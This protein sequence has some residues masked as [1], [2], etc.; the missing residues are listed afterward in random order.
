M[1]SRLHFFTI[2]LIGFVD[3]LGVGLVYPIFAALLFDSDY[4]LVPEDFPSSYRGALLGLLICLAPLMKF[5][6]APL[7]GALSDYKGRRKTLLYG[8]GVGCIGYTLAIFGIWH[9]S[10]MILLL[11]RMLVGISEGTVSVAQ[12][13]IADISSAETKANRFA[14]FNGCLGIGFTIGPFL[15]GKLADPQFASWCGYAVPFIVANAL[16][17]INLVL[18]SFSF[19]ETNAVARQ[20]KNWNVLVGLKNMAK[21][22]RWPKL[23]GLFLTAF[24]F[25]FGWS[26]FHEFVP[27]LLRHRFQFSLSDVGNYYAYGGA[28]YAFSASLAILPLIKYLA[29]ERLLPNAL[30]CCAFCMVLFNI[31]P[32]AQYIWWLMPPFMYLLATTF[33][34]ATALTSKA[35]DRENQGE[36]LGVYQSVIALAMGL[37]PLLAGAAVGK[38]PELA[39]YGGA[40][41]MALGAAIFILSKRQVAEE[42]IAS[43]Q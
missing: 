24:L 12:A 9:K 26:F 15:G 5:F 34:T 38:Y 16:C 22:L 37:S 3:Y 18:I 11:Y 13:V 39:G 29:P 4:P 33:P 8:I 1:S 42:P 10:L 14:L 43:R 27:V 30:I 40:F 2:L 25:S 20:V 6:S 35:A 19:P 41:V 7:L 36:V 17:L 23:R 32:N 28:W 21:V 31:I